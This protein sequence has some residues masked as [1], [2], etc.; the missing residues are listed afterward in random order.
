MIRFTLYSRAWCHLCED[1][2]RALEAALA[3]IPGGIDYA[4]DI[5]DIDTDA[6]IAPELAAR[7]DELVPV[8][9]AGRPGDPPEQLCHY[10]LDPARLAAFLAG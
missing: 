6:D 10:F 4:I 7:Y 5:I 9:F 2:Q 8:L 1:M 3:A